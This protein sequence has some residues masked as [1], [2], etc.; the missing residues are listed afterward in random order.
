MFCSHFQTLCHPE[1]KI[2]VAE[3]R[4]YN[5]F[6]Y[7]TLMRRKIIRETEFALVPH[8]MGL[9]WGK[10]RKLGNSLKNAYHQVSSAGHSLVRKLLRQILN[11]QSASENEAEE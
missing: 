8:W 9:G 4:L 2:I 3:L 1:R 7:L 11:K 10:L 6:R 5:S